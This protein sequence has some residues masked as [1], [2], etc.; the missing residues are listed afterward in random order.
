MFLT[1]QE[2]GILSGENG[3]GLQYAMELLVTIGEVFNSDKLIDITRAHWALSGQEGDLYFAKRLAEGDAKTKVPVTTNPD[4]DPQLR[5]QFKVDL[6]DNDLALLRDT[7]DACDRLNVIKSFSCTPFLEKD[8]PVYG[9][10]VSFSESSAS[11][12]INAVYGALT[13]RESSVSALAAGIVGKTPNFGLHLKENRAPTVVVKVSASVRGDFDLG[14]LG[15]HLGKVVEPNSIPYLTHIKGTQSMEGLRDFGALLNT[16]NAV[17]M[18][19]IVG[20]TPEA[21]EFEA[22]SH[23]GIEKLEITEKDLNETRR[24]FSN[25]HGEINSVFMGCPHST[26]SEIN[27]VYRLLNGRKIKDDIHFLIF[28][29]GV[30]FKILQTSGMMGKLN[31]LGVRVL[32]DSCVD[33]PV[34]K[35][36]EGRIGATNSAKAAYYRARRNQKFTILDIPDLVEAG[37]RGF[38]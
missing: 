17:A 36:A 2:E 13:N 9:E 31:S 27:S 7:Y 33:E 12:F 6:T 35:F 32:K 16:T 30:N 23:N 3:P 15:W 10:H 26:V 38:V 21:K 20:V 25:Y 28:T 4:W 24:E 1:R 8:H 34:F 22:S 14:L 29:S 18:Y 5:T 37:V 19:H 11:P